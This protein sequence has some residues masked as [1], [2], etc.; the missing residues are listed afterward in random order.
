MGKAFIAIGLLAAAQVGCHNE[1]PPPRVPVPAST[2]G[3]PAVTYE[4][5]QMKPLP[6]PRNHE[7]VNAPPY[8]DEPLVVHHPPE[9]QQFVEAYKRVG[10]PRIVVFVNRTLEGQIIPIRGAGPP[11]ATPEQAYLRSG[12]Y[13]EAAA[14]TLDYEAVESILTDWL[15]SNGQVTI[16]SPTMVRQK[17]TEQ[18]IKDLSSGVP[19]MLGIVAKQLDADVLVQAQA[20]PTQQTK[21]GLEVR[22][23]VEA[24]NTSGGESIGR[25][26]V[27]VPP[28]LEKTQINSYTRYLA[29]KLM[30]DMTGSWLAPPPPQRAQAAP[31]GP[32]TAAT[33]QP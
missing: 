12:E 9:Q 28:P 13:D 18:Q 25:A 7:Q 30:D 17:M 20:H 6:E 3:H 27:D 19:Q 4:H 21:Q 15:A 32:T 2:Y 22:I 14:K 5:D 10:A 33:T 11:D 26:V 1:P 29:R 24:L 23:I 8:D 16:V 31:A